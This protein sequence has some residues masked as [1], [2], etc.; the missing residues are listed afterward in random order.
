MIELKACPFC[1]KRDC[2][3]WTDEA[4]YYELLGRNGSASIRLSCNRCKV[5]IWEHSNNDK[6]YDKK[7]V[8]LFKKWNNRTACEEQDD[9]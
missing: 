7:L 1:G 5:D 4:T 3:E 8:R 2:I 9:D 6:N